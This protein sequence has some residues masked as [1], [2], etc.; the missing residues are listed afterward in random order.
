MV[1]NLNSEVKFENYWISTNLQILK[2]FHL[3]SKWSHENKGLHT[4]YLWINIWLVTKWFGF[5]SLFNCISTLVGYFMPKPSLKNSIDTIEPRTVTL[6]IVVCVHE[7]IYIYIYIYIAI[8]TLANNLWWYPMKGPKTRENFGKFIYQLQPKTKT[9]FRKLERNLI[10]LYNQNVSL[11]F[12]QTWLKEGLL[13]NHTHMYIYI[14]IV[15]HRQIYF[16]RSELISVA[17]HTSF[18]VDLNAN[19]RL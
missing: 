18:L 7:Y 5:V 13:P 17:R 9:L 11:L 19:Q 6:K 10:K 4:N 2:G 15:I 12:N 16:V 14:Y 8:L 3:L 1:C